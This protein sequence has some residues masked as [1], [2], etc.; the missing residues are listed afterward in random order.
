VLL[1]EVAQPEIE[2][3][4]T[5]E[6]PAGSDATPMKS[7][8][9]A[10]ELLLLFTNARRPLSATEIARE[11]QLHKSSASRIL[12]TLAAARF[13]DRDVETGRY[14]L[15]L[16]ILS[17][18]GHVLSR[19]QLPSAA[20]R[21]LELLADRVGETITI[22]AWN[23][24]EAVNLDQIIGGRSVLNMSP[25]GRINPAHCTA[26][27]KVFLA[28]LPEDRDAVLEE[29]LTRFTPKTITTRRRLLSEIGKVG[30]A[31]YAVNEQEFD[32]EISSIAAP[33]F[34]AKGVPAYA[35]AV[36]VPHFRYDAATKSRLIA[37]ILDTARYLSGLLGYAPPPSVKP[38]PAKRGP[39]AARG[40]T[41]AV[42]ELSD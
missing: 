36:T 11:L 35:V 27:G 28:Y 38:T 7:I 41:E 4:V 39:K 26:T 3:R 37:E 6:R 33:V 40:R 25:P 42:A 21:H 13:V 10:L 17:L 12:A 18:A 23:G 2:R 30:A 8:S 29:P 14:T 19:Y 34:N 16:G 1:R 24:R 5:L 9:H 20:R 31:G 32:L 22:S 15:G